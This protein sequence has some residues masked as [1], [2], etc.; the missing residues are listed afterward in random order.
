[1]IENL[2]D[3]GYCYHGSADRTLVKIQV[4]VH[5]EHDGMKFTSLLEKFQ[6]TM[7]VG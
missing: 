2:L 5:F 4:V 1:M 7:V 6:V 3:P